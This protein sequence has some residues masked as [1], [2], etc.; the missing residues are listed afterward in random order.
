M[1]TMLKVTIDVEA[2]NKAIQTGELPKIIG[3]LVEKINPEAAYFTTYQGL[4]TAFFVFDMTDTSNMPP[5]FEP[6]FEQLKAQ[7]ELTPVMNRAELE[8]GFKKLMGN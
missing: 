1:R 4:R 8:T 5:L 3:A 7:I 2:G 6:L